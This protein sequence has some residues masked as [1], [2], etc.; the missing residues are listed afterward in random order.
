M[1]NGADGSLSLHRN[2]LSRLAS[3]QS[4]ALLPLPARPATGF[5]GAPPPAQCGSGR[6]EL[7]MASSGVFA[8]Q[9][10]EGSSCAH[11]PPP[12]ELLH[13][14]SAVP[15]SPGPAHQLEMAPEPDSPCP[16]SATA[17]RH[18][19]VAAA[20]CRTH[21]PAAALLAAGAL[22]AAAAFQQQPVTPTDFL[23]S[24][25]SV[26]SVV[27]APIL[28]RRCFDDGGCGVAEPPLAPAPSHRVC[29]PAVAPSVAARQEHTNL[30]L[31]QLT[32]VLCGAPPSSSA[33]ALPIAGASPSA[34]VMQQ[35]A[36]MPSDF[37]RSPQPA[38]SVAAAADAFRR[39]SDNAAHGVAEPFFLFAEPVCGR[40]SFRAQHNAVCAR[41]RTNTHA[42]VV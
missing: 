25:Q 8:C 23:R 32:D 37:I 21:T 14:P 40:P 17:E 7:E 22:P 34:A 12:P 26:S 9:H 15:F 36:A 35:Y 4:G 29:P 30:R 38:S 19:L 39:C 5:V 31:V 11:R 42:E 6:C 41:H 10:G 28:F 3:D 16:G 1:W 20:G 24:S 13:L 18:A 33:A 27:A 2:L